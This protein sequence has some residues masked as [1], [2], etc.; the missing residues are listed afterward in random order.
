MV[1]IYYWNVLVTF[2]LFR[3]PLGLTR[4]G[5]NGLNV[6]FRTVYDIKLRVFPVRPFQLSHRPAH[7]F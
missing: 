5:L 4:L 3:L 2:L 6:T 7:I 1:E